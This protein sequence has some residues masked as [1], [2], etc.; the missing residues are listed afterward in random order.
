MAANKPPLE[1]HLGVNAMVADFVTV[2][3]N[4]QAGAYKYSFEVDEQLAQM[5]L[6]ILGGL[7]REGESRP[8]IIWRP[9]PSE[10]A[11]ARY[12]A[13]GEFKQIEGKPL[14][15]PKGKKDDEQDE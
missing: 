8:V 2:T 13:S 11:A 6:D 1:P 3:K 15:L 12:A 14:K 4:R 7:P 9:T 10:I 5:F